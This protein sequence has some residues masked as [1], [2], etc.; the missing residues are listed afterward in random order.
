MKW[1]GI[2][3]RASVYISSAVNQERHRIEVAT[4]GCEVDG[5]EAK[6]ELVD[7]S[8]EYTERLIQLQRVAALGSIVEQGA[9]RRTNRH[10]R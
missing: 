4:L 9:A 6:L 3:A 7:G 8:R 10:A 5:R 1:R 2:V